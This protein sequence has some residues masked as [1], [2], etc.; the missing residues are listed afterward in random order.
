M[1]P[2]ILGNHQGSESL[3]NMLVD[4]K[5]LSFTYQWKCFHLIDERA[6]VDKKSKKE[7]EKEKDYSVLTGKAASVLTVGGHKGSGARRLADM[8]KNVRREQVKSLA[9]RL[10]TEAFSEEGP[11]EDASQALGKLVGEKGRQSVAGHVCRAGGL[12]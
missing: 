11:S 4:I 6:G 7:K 1:F 5:V 10:Y 9:Q 2:Y 12:G 8:V 3:K